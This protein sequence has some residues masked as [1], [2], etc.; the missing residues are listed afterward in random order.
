LLLRPGAA[1]PRHVLMIGLGAASLPKFLY[2][3]RPHARLTVVEIDAAVV[4]A[5]EQ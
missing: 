2:R 1:R 3:H 5:A 4:R